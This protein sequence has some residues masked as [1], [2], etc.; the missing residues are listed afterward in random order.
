MAP[1]KSKPELKQKTLLG[2]F[3]KST[4]STPSSK[5]TQ[6]KPAPKPSLNAQTTPPKKKNGDH[7][8]EAEARK[9]DLTSSVASSFKSSGSRVSSR[10]NDTPPT[11]DP[12]DVDMLSDLTDEEIKIIEKPVSVM[13]SGNALN[14]WH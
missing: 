4:A 5:A 14:A 13:L 11:S 8:E 12:V 7:D 10:D 3:N 2:F 6:P 9:I 1:S